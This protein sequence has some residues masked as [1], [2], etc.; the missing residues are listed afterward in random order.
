VRIADYTFK[1]LG[2]RIMHH[3]KNVL[4]VLLLTCMLLLIACGTPE[5]GGVAGELISEEPILEEVESDEL[6]EEPDEEAL[7]G[8]ADEEE[9]LLDENEMDEGLEA[10]E[11]VISIDVYQ[12]DEEGM[13]LITESIAIESLTPENVLEAL[14]GEGVLAS[15]IQVLRFGES[16]VGGQKMI[17]LDLS[18]EFHSFL[19]GQGTT[20]EFIVIGSLVNTFLSAFQVDNIIITVGGEALSTPHV[21][22]MAEPM[23][24]FDN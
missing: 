11:G 14:I 7:D 19:S 5:G 17:E 1:I 12:S 10:D 21:G 16:S 15:N 13:G 9:A 22:E 23:G 6:Q 3:R 20:G 4:G 24:R 18:T 2:G 8:E